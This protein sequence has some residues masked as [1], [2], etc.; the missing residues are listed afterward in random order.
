MKAPSFKRPSFNR[1]NIAKPKPLP[2]LAKAPDPLK[3]VRLPDDIEESPKVELDA[4]QA[5]FRE[6]AAQEAERFKDA[7]DSGYYSCLVFE[8]REQLDA[9]LTGIGMLNRGDL[10]LDGREVARALGIDLPK[11]DRAGGTP[12]KVD[13]RLLR[14]AR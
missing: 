8:N 7:T 1:P 11:V 9:F 5:G 10:Y 2:S 6:R 3:N 12:G 13:P 14:L 4:V